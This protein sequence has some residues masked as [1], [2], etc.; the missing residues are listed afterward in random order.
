MGID[1]TKLQQL[2]E[3]LLVLDQSSG[4]RP[5]RNGRFGV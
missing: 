2:D 3:M 4:V 5:G 1:H